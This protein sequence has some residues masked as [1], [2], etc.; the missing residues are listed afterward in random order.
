MTFSEPPHQSGTAWY[1]VHSKPRQEK[2][3]KENLERQGYRI[4]L[5]TIKITKI[6]RG[7]QQYRFEPL[8]PRYLFFQPQSEQHSIA[9][10]RST[11]GV[12]RLVRFGIT[13]A[14]IR[15]QTILELMAWETRQHQSNFEE[16]TNIQ[17]GKTVVVTE[18][19]FKGME[20]LVSQVSEQRVLVL[21]ELLG[22]EQKLAFEPK[23][24]ELAE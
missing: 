22:Q 8:F 9:P 16:L 18:G 13:P 11:L 12:T 14:L 17:P 7:E 6:W 5:P 10:V 3:A 21:L 1:V 19:A 23:Q 15:D 2:L 24:L 4:Y 20:G